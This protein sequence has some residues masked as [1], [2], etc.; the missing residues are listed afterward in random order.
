[1][2]GSC[3][4]TDHDT[5]WWFYMMKKIKLVCNFQVV[6]KQECIVPCDYMIVFYVCL[7]LQV[8]CFLFLSTFAKI[9]PQF[10]FV[11]VWFMNIKFEPAHK[12]RWHI[13]LNHRDKDSAWN[14]KKW[15]VGTLDSFLHRSANTSFSQVYIIFN[16]C[17]QIR[18]QLS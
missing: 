17:P 11:L 5:N 12:I 15:E 9:L 4:K 7:L 16:S 1:M 18:T 14:W 3:V 2:L 10:F 13:N 6:P 8:D